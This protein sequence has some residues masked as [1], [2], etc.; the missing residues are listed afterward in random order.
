M[1]KY[2]RLKFSLKYLSLVLLFSPAISY[3]SEPSERACVVLLHGMGRSS[4]SMGKAAKSL[5]EAGYRTVNFDYPSTKYSIDYLA[6][7][8]IPRALAKCQSNSLEAVHFITHSLGGILLRQYL[9]L[10]ELPQGKSR[11]NA[12]PAEQGQR[13]CR[14][15][16]RLLAIQMANGTGG[17]RTGN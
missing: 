15:S 16:A 6:R 9:Q 7:T 13:A 2:G 11:G 5:E 1:A 4:W 14:I 3:P 10:N 8:Y 12:Q 17:T